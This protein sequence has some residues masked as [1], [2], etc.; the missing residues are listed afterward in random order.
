MTEPRV[1]HLVEAYENGRISWSFSSLRPTPSWY[2]HCSFNR[3]GNW[4]IDLS[5]HAPT[6]FLL[7]RGSSFRR[8]ADVCPTEQRDRRQECRERREGRSR[9][10]ERAGGVRDQGRAEQSVERSAL[11]LAAGGEARS[12][13][14]GRMEQPR[15]CLRARRQVRGREEGLRAGPAAG[16]EEPDD[17]A[18]LRSLQRNQ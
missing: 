3:A 11:P 2:V 6:D 14:R 4:Y 10:V 12:G 17:P 15:H 18:E 9:E 16:S 7:S 1:T 8:R 5:L 13:L